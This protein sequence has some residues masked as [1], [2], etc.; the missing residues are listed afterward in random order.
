VKGTQAAEPRRDTGDPI[1]ELARRLFGV[2]APYPIQRFVIANTLDGLHQIVVLPTGSG[3]S[4]C[5]Q[6]PQAVLD[7]PTLV[8]VPLLALLADQARRLLAAEV[9]A[10][11]L[12]GGLAAADRE[13]AL[14]ALLSGAARVAF[15]TPE[16]LATDWARRRMPSRGIAHLVVDEAH[17]IPEWGPRFRPAYLELG[18]FVR[19]AAPRVVTAFTATAS[20]AVLQAIRETLFPGHAPLMVIG[21]ADRPEITYRVVPSLWMPRDIA[22]LVAA[23]P[24]PALAFGRTRK[25]VERLAGDLARRLTDREVRFYHAGLERTERAGIEGW[26]LP[27]RR[28]VLVATSAYGMGVDKPDIRM[29]VHAGAPPSVEAYLQESGRAGR[30]GAPAQAVLVHGYPGRGPR[31]A[32]GTVERAREDRM[33]GYLRD[34]AGASCRRAALLRMLGQPAPPCAGCD[35]CRGEAQAAPEGLAT[36]L[37]HVERHRRRFTVRETA[38]RLAGRAGGPPLLPGWSLD[39]I[40]GALSALQASGMVARKRGLLWPN[41]LSTQGNARGISFSDVLSFKS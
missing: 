35:V 29:V 36:I 2:T 19:R 22:R 10:V 28:G 32:E 23:C 18:S 12:R 40:L 14:A 1:E 31:A 37:R 25:E 5:W 4:L 21:D 24:G 17:C 13:A 16:F 27:S 11:V 33:L 30:D 38:L 41:R 9:P 7:G 39:D 3:K 15:S 26:F 20:P 6:V 34:P 8:V